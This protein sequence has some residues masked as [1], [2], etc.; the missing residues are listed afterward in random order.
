MAQQVFF[1]DNNLQ[2]KFLAKELTP[3]IIL[4]S[5]HKK[6]M[7]NT[8]ELLIQILKFMLFLA[9]ILLSTEPLWQPNNSFH[10]V[11]L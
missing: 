6:S 1:G 2:E 8:Q 10:S 11:L 7:A 3:S 9:L 4:E 5:N